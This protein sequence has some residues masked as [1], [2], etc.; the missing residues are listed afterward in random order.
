MG[1]SPRSPRPTDHAPPPAE[2]PQTQMPGDGFGGRVAGEG[3]DGW[4]RLGEGGREMAAAAQRSLGAWRGRAGGSGTRKWLRD[5]A[6]RGRAGG[7]G[8]GRLRDSGEEEARSA[9][10]ESGFS[11]CGGLLTS[12][13]SLV[14]THSLWGN[15]TLS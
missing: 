3:R 12:E 10:T 7:S 8:R 4:V 13:P 6:A 9:Q 11:E 2:R 5:A 15:H 1:E 14:S